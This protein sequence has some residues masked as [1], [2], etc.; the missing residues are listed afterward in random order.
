MTR[1]PQFLATRI[2]A[3]L[4]LALFPACALFRESTPEPPIE[5][6]FRGNTSYSERELLDA[7]GR[8]LRS[9]ERTQWKRSLID[10][11]ASEL[12]EF[13]QDEGFPHVRVAYD[14][15]E[16]AGDKGRAT[17][18]IREGPRAEVV[19]LVFEGN[20]SLG[21]HGLE[22]LFDWPGGGTFERKAR[23][24]TESKARRGARE[25][26][27]A[28]QDRG[29]ND[30]EVEPPVATFDETGARVNVLVRVH[31]GIRYE[32][33]AV[34]VEGAD[35]IE[36]ALL[37]RAWTNQLGKP[38]HERTAVEIRGRIED[39]FAERG[40]PD[41]RALLVS[42]DG[43]VRGLT[44][45]RF[46]VETGPQVT[47]GA[48]TLHG[49]E[50]TQDSFVRSRLALKSGALY[51]RSDERATISDLYRTGVFEKADLRWTPSADTERDLAIDLTETKSL[52]AW[53]EP[54]Y[55]SYERLRASAGMRERNLFGTGRTLLLEGTGGAVA[56]NTRASLIDP[57]SFGRDTTAEYSVFG[58]QREEP[59]F[60]STELGVRAQLTHKLSEHWQA[61]VA[62]QYK[63]SG[64]DDVDADVLLDPQLADDVNIS[65]VTVAAAHDTRDLAIDPSRGNT[66][67]ASAEF[68][69]SLLGSEIDF[70]RF[71]GLH[72]SIV[73]LHA[74]S[75]L[76]VLS[77]RTGCIVPTG[78]TTDIPLQE[79]FFNGGEST[80]RS[81]E[82]D[83]L[84]PQDADGTP[85]G[86]E[87]YSVLSIELRQHIGGRWKGAL[88]GDAGNVVPDHTD[89][90]ELTDI[91]YAIGVGLRY[92]LPIGPIRVDAALNP[93]PED[94]E[95]DGAI[96]VS[97]GLAF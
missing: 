68:A 62:Y 16:Q 89:Y 39:L 60:Q 20:T 96:H 76:L 58:G 28:Y 42:R 75:T 23:W 81:F 35:A 27:L 32:L 34:E 63:F 47:V 44:T 37:A 90:F 91:R 15:D 64:I 74:D 3:V 65:S 69:S 10:D 17:F 43:D 70:V 8:G 95:A 56:W 25:V 80:V 78:A 52:E 88:F 73:R 24:Y 67:R 40:Y 2:L 6:V 57:W 31:E 50:S 38:F 45:L 72:T 92:S 21:S 33:K 41:V 13:Y 83:Q 12:E 84:G 26:E 19:E 54:G 18:R 53:F 85:L 86:G 30:C 29:W 14:L 79:R 36:P 94:G 22:A 66:T 4:A 7:A 82:E 77:L 87:A 46:R 55:G 71:Q 49:N 1:A 9:Y 93:D 97:L 48:I 59:S 5:V 51:K 61:S 11:V